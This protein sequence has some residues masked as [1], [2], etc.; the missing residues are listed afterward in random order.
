MF[1][2]EG[3]VVKVE[4]GYAIVHTERGSSCDGC[5]AKASCHALGGSDNSK[6]MEMKVINDIGA[7]TGDK[8]KVAIDSLVLLK[9]SFLV[10]VL[11]LVAMIT[12]GI[13]GENYAKNN[14]PAHDPD[15]FAGGVGILCLVVS[16]LFIRF[17]SRNLEKKRE[18]QPRIIRIT[19]R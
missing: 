5:G 2:E 16:F 1:E 7:E 13:L 11:P 6:T 8:V 14:M 18:Y 12:G 10:Y 4:E 9:S 3:R 19:G 17:W 15:L